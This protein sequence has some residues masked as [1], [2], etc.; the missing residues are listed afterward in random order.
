[1]EI[2]PSARLENIVVHNLDK[3]I[4]IYDLLTNKAYN[5]N[6]T[7]AIVYQN[8]DGQTTFD[9]LKSKHEFTDD[10]IYF[11][12]DELKANNLIEGATISYFGNLSRREIVKRIGLSTMIALPVISSLVA[13]KAVYAASCAPAGA[14]VSASITNSSN[15]TPTNQAAAANALRA[16]CCSGSISSYTTN[17]CSNG[18]GET[19]NANGTCA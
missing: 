12:V 2:L 4:L 1:M 7:S 10:L 19:C 6:E 18:A 8:C 11:A 9:E 14:T 17:G 5:L 15:D 13:P 16:K 3:E